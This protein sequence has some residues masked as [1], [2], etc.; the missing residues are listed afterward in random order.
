M[1]GSMKVVRCDLS[2]RQFF[3]VLARL[4]YRKLERSFRDPEGRLGRCGH[5][6]RREGKRSFSTICTEDVEVE[7]RRAEQRKGTT[8][9]PVAKIPIPS[10]ANNIEHM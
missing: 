4:N 10:A 9:G 7:I 6:V 3:R 1:D 2:S 8:R 5:E